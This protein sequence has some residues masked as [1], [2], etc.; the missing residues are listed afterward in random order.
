MVTLGS[1]RQ[2]FALEST[3]L[4]ESTGALWEDQ[5][6]FCRFEKPIHGFFEQKN[7][8]F[9]KKLAKNEPIDAAPGQ[10]IPRS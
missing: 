3:E 10:F 2:D 1:D 8:K 7:H 5:R 4:H 6:S 9:T